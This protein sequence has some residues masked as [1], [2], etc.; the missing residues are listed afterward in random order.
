MRD[1]QASVVIPAYN[2]AGHIERSVSSALEQTVSNIEVL[3]CD[4]ASLD[5]TADV[6][7]RMTARDGRVRLLRNAINGGPAA[8]RNRGLEAARGA[9]IVLLD[10]DDTFLPHRIETLIAL[11]E[12]HK[13]DLVADN[14]L[15][16]PEGGVPL[17]P[18]I[19]PELLPGGRWLSPAEFVEGNIGSR[20]TPRVSYGFLQPVIR[21]SF[22]AAHEIRYDARNRFGED[23]LF[24]LT[25][26]L[27]GARWWLTPEPMYRYLVRAGT[28]TEVQ[29]A[30]DLLRIR[31][32]EQEVLR[33]AAVVGADPKLARALRRHARKMDHFYCYR[34][35]TDELK[36]RAVGRAL[37]FV[38]ERPDGFHY[39]MLEGMAQ[40][41][42]VTLKALRGGFRNEGRPP[43]QAARASR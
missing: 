8:A 29:S 7:A 34:A 24:A 4:D 20:W 23:F 26:L 9:W 19:S 33:N 37:R 10:A 31:T 30:S 43:Q 15:L 12:R 40:A 32:F 35:F 1:I 3:V 5:N 21:R 18:M 13:A 16:C 14:L 11:G 17:G 6:V 38:R 22:L 42:R 39:I 28:L 27:H 36:K 25:C 41:P 2:A